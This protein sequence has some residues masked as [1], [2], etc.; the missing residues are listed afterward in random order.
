MS[1]DRF[2]QFRDAYD[3]SAVRVRA[4]TPNDGTDL[5]ADEWTRGLYVG[6]A[7][8]VA[9]IMVG[10]TASVVIPALAAGVLHPI[11]V[12][13]VLATGTTATGIRGFI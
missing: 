12:R 13:R 10:D 6:V 8:D 5:P 1:Q 3:G 11:R 7:G 9:V 4:I 2:N